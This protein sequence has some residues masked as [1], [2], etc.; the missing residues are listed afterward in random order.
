MIQVTNEN[1]KLDES[2]INEIELRLPSHVWETNQD[3]FTSNTSERGR[4]SV[5]FVK[6]F[7]KHTHQLK[8]KNFIEM[9]NN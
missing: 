3:H 7:T 8:H 5:I 9:F 2:V 4:A 1:N 6:W